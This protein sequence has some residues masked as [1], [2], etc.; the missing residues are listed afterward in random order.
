MNEMFFFSMIMSI[1]SLYV[2]GN[3]SRILRNIFIFIIFFFS[4]AYLLG[5]IGLSFDILPEHLSFLDLGFAL[6]GRSLPLLLVNHIVFLIYILRDIGRERHES[7]SSYFMNM[8]FLFFFSN[9]LFISKN[10]I[11]A[12]VFFEIEVYFS[13]FLVATNINE[14]KTMNDLLFVNSMMT[15]L[16]IS[17]VVYYEAAPGAA[18]ALFITAIAGRLFM[19]PF[20]ARFFDSLKKASIN[21]LGYLMFVLFSSSVSLIDFASSIVQPAFVSANMYLIFVPFVIFSLIKA[22]SA[23]TLKHLLFYL[24][25]MSMSFQIA[26]LSLNPADKY[27][28]YASFSGVSM[29]YAI[30]FVMCDRIEELFA[31]TELKKLE[32]VHAFLPFYPFIFMFAFLS[33]SFF[34]TS[35]TSFSNPILSG[36]P[37][38]FDAVFVFVV[39]S[40]LAVAFKVMA[41]LFFTDIN[42]GFYSL[43][44]PQVRSKAAIANDFINLVIVTVL[45]LIASESFSPYLSAEKGL[46]SIVKSIIFFQAEGR[47]WNIASFA[48]ILT[49]N[50][51]LYGKRKGASES[52][53]DRSLEIRYGKGGIAG[54]LPIEK[55][56]NLNGLNFYG[57]DEQKLMKAV[58]HF[59][60]DTPVRFLARALFETGNLISKIYQRS[61]TAVLITLLLVLS[62]VIVSAGALK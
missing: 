62:I 18:Y 19:L 16:L 13:L 49:L 29:I 37:M 34:P 38:I 14:R 45:L 35:V 47:I 51:V 7:E 25:I 42:A 60:M 21:L 46:V 48:L 41:L 39:F 40:T 22:L 28:S 12:A 43:K 44:R 53:R 8:F 11:T 1:L 6:S 10:I 26:F 33:L 54:F 23:S 27:A 5:G 36:S 2:I 59:D 58:K 17:S 3:V 50:L 56:V 15:V 24:M 30:L 57:F 20:N 9:M 32:G 55:N 31:T 61:M 4:S 52:F